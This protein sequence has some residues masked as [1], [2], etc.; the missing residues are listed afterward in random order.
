MKIKILAS[1]I[2]AAIFYSVLCASDTCIQQF[3]DAQ[4]LLEKARTTAVLTEKRGLLKKAHDML[5]DTVCNAG[6]FRMSAIYFVSQAINM[7]DA[8]DINGADE[9]TSMAID[10]VKKAT[11]RLI[12]EMTEQEQENQY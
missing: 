9:K 4:Q 10:K 7:A 5:N 2:V 1:A 6:T 3:Q 11:N 12:D 8:S